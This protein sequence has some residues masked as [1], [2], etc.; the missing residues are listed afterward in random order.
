MVFQNTLPHMVEESRKIVVSLGTHFRKIYLEITEALLADEL[1]LDLGNV[2]A[3][4]SFLRYQ[5]VH[6]L[7]YAPHGGTELHILE[8]SKDSQCILDYLS[9]IF[10]RFVRRVVGDEDIAIQIDSLY[11]FLARKRIV[12]LFLTVFSA[13]KDTASPDLVLNLTVAGFLTVLMALNRTFSVPVLVCYQRAP[14]LRIGRPRDSAVLLLSGTLHAATKCCRTDRARRAFFPSPGPRRAQFPVA[15]RINSRHS[16][17]FRALPRFAPGPR[18]D[19]LRWLFAARR[20]TDNTSP[21]Y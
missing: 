13:L 5:N 14:R 3:I 15:R 4:H 17:L 9:L 1:S 6:R 7:S 12:S 2:P 19:A 18:R 21:F 8:L 10:C 20:C 16:S 11:L